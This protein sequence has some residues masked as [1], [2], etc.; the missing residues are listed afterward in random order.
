M[1]QMLEA[2]GTNIQFGKELAPLTSFKTGGRARYFI[3]PEDAEEVIRAVKAARKLKIPFF[4]M[5]DGSNLLVSD[6][7]YNG[8]VIQ[9]A[10]RE[11][12]LVSATE[13]RC[14]S[15]E[16]LIALVDFATAN[17]LTGLEF[18]AGIY[19][20][21]G[22]AIYGNAGAFGGEI[23]NLISSVT[24]ID[25]QG[26]M[27]NVGSEYCKFDYRHS[28]LKESG[29][30]IVAARYKL[31]AGDMRAIQA[32]VDEILAQRSERHPR[33]RMSAGCFF[34][35][36]PDE[37]EKHGKRAAGELLEEI[38]AKELSVGDAKVFDKHA[39]IIVNSGNATSKDIR[40]LAD[41]LKDKVFQRFGVELI[42]EIQ[43]L[44]EF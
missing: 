25:R 29:D 40:Q 11:L 8:L 33:E 18:A 10:I 38:G 15:G 31:E 5:G 20:S 44:G 17:S 22:G 6:S 13:I 12:T 34:K 21:T 7:G 14:G 39:N 43:Q 27:K 4:V 36:I 37:R 42:E 28:F 2:F 41:I 23:G 9:I 35:N 26:E 19:G 32:K 3:K 16:L 1:A 30:I 24:L